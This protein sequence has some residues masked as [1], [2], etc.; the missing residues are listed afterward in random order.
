MGGSCICSTKKELEANKKTVES[1]IAKTLDVNPSKVKIIAIIEVQQHKRRNLLENTMNATEQ[2][3]AY[4]E[5]VYEVEVKDE[6]SAK[7]IVVG[8]KKE[9]FKS[10]LNSNIQTES[11]SFNVVVENVEKPT[12][13]KINYYI[14]TDRIVLK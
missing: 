3:H 2:T 12:I 10:T 8:M 1:A 9:T 7:G 11:S 5:V 14:E 13:K 6:E 4:I